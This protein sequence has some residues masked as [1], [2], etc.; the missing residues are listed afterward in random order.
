MTNFWSP[1]WTL[2]IPSTNCWFQ[3]WCKAVSRSVVWLLR[4]NSRLLLSINPSPQFGLPL[5]CSEQS[6]PRSVLDHTCF[7]HSEEPQE[8][9]LLLIP[10]SCSFVPALLHDLKALLGYLAAKRTLRYP[11]TVLTGFSCNCL[12]KLIY[13]NC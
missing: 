8:T 3:L 2:K 11:V 4:Q 7:W 9:Q 12:S 5:D 13:L 10:K 1:V 6:L